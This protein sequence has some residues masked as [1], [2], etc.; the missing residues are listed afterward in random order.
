M[1]RATVRL[2]EPLRELADRRDAVQVEAATVRAA[3]DGLLDRYPALRRHLMTDDG[4]F[5]PHVNL[6]LNQDDVRHGGGPETPIGDGDTITIVPSVAGGAPV[7]E[8]APLSRE[9]TLRYARHLVLPGVGEAGQRRLKSAKVLVVGAG[10]L[11]SPASMYLTAAGVGTLGIVDFDVVEASNLQRQPLYGESDVGRPKLDVAVA[12]LRDMNPHVDV[13]PYPFRLTSDNALDVIE[14]YDVV[15]DGTDNFPSR[16][17]INDACVL[18]DKRYV[19]GSILRFEGQVSVFGAADGPCYRCLF[20]EPPPPDLVPDCAEGGVLGVLPGIIGSLQGLE[21]IKLITGA[22]EPLIGRLLLF[23]ALKLRWRE[24]RLRRNAECPVCGDDPTVTDLIDYE[25]FCG[26]GEAADP[27]A[28]AARESAG[29]ATLPPEIGATELS[30]RLDRGD[31]PAL[32]DVREPFEWE[33]AHLGEFGARLIPMGEVEA[34][35]SELDRDRETV[36]YCRSGVR[37]GNVVAWLRSQGWERA[38][39]LTGGILAWGEEVDPSV[40]RY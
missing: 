3:L 27:V 10:G 29:E 19:Y 34:R 25:A 20:R 39:N 28:A 26:A 16:Y 6:Y 33:I 37:S 21:A 1:A 12:R 38:R 15:V 18:L 14:D 40:P 5:R 11:G 22:G 9:E 7:G 36:F 4:A 24:L 2:P 17:L 32:I 23:D 8:E 35:I 13:A 30:E 31:A